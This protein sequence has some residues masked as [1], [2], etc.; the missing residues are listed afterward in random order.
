MK[1]ILTTIN[2]RLSHLFMFALLIGLLY[3]FA[4]T[5]TLAQT[6]CQSVTAAVGNNIPP[7]RVD[8]SCTLSPQPL[9]LTVDRN[10]QPLTTRITFNG[11]V[12]TSNP[13]FPPLYQTFSHDAGTCPTNGFT[14][15][16]IMEFSQPVSNAA[17]TLFGG[18]N[19][20][21]MYMA[22]DNA[23]HTLQATG[24][25]FFFPG[26]GITT[27]TFTALS[28]P[29]I[30]PSLIDNCT[31]IGCS[32]ATG[33]FPGWGFGISEV[34]FTPTCYD[35]SSV[36]FEQLN[37]VQLEDNPF[38]LGNE[39]M[40][41]GQQYGGGNRFFPDATTSGGQPQ[42]ELIVKARI[43]AS[44]AGVPIYF[45]AFDVDDST[46]LFTIVHNGNDN[47]GP[48]LRPDGIPR[49]GEFVGFHGQSV[50]TAM[51]NSSGEATLHFLVTMQPGD[52]FKIAASNNPNSIA[53]FAVSGQQIQEFPGGPALIDS[54]AASVMSP[55]L[56]VWRYA[57]VEV[58][59][60]PDP[61]SDT[62]PG[63]DTDPERN[64]IKGTIMQITN[65]G[66]RLTLAPDQNV[67][68]LTLDDGSKNLS[69]NGQQRG[70]GRFQNGT[71][72]IGQLV[73]AIRGNG[74]NRDGTEFVDMQQ[75]IRIPFSLTNGTQP[76]ITGVIRELDATTRVITLD[77]SLGG[78][79]RNYIGGTLIITG[80]TFTVSQASGSR[81]TIMETPSLRFLLTDDDQ[82]STPFLVSPM[83]AQ[84]NLDGTAFE[85]M[86]P[87]T[88]SK[89]NLFALAYIQP[90]YLGG[91]TTS[92]D[93]KRNM[94][95]AADFHQIRNAED[96]QSDLNFWVLYLQ[97][98]FQERPT[99]DVD[100][101]FTTEGAALGVT[102][103]DPPASSVNLHGSAIFSE[104]IRD[105]ERKQNLATD[106]CLKLTTIHESGHQFGLPDIP[107]S[108][109]I[110]GG[111][112][113]QGCP[114]GS[115]KFIPDHQKIIRMRLKPQD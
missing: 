35:I 55:L 39:V 80:M 90:V 115:L 3:G 79:A 16:L 106:L 69:G 99:A 102:D 87:S 114:K 61:P 65:R 107:A 48:P 33:P 75:A 49:E 77:T 64:F 24:G 22:E 93:F 84:T 58:D 36:T 51:T 66:D 5:I 28:T 20:Q 17:V 18:G 112:M 92:P 56:T 95:G 63:A 32:L 9:T 100:P 19:N 103:D 10:W 113:K 14:P 81:V 27:I 53:N 109:T 45:R 31:A 43:N 11:G 110:D 37:G 44:Q 104:T 21:I 76:Q 89:K 12:P 57:H 82:A 26:A 30:T 78:N 38:P 34:S 7:G 23:G 52:N 88:D 42:R 41:N 13:T 2:N 72:T 46:G 50:A 108:S 60:M 111:I 29:L 62:A 40:V 85:L 73:G 91:G 54:N 74:I 94:T 71:I 70:D 86:Q 8:P 25:I 98:A 59:S 83:P 6:P 101:D 68:T 4:P 96:F 67:A 15:K 1:S 47:Q 97:G 105:F